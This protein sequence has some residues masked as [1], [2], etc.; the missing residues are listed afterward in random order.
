MANTISNTIVIPTL[1][2]KM[3][4][5]GEEVYAYTSFGSLPVDRGKKM[6]SGWKRCIEAEDK[7]GMPIFENDIVLYEGRHF[8]VVYSRSHCGWTLLSNQEQSKSIPL[9]INGVE[10]RMVE[11]A[12]IIHHLEKPI[13]FSN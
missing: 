7:N 3:L 10:P 2:M 8:E 12:N 4:D 6:L 13:S 1:R 9:G 11:I 5:Q